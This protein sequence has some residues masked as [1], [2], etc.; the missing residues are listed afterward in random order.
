MDSKIT[1][2]LEEVSIEKVC[3]T[4][5]NTP[6]DDK[7]IS[8]YDNSDQELTNKINFFNLINETFGKIVRNLIKINMITYKELSRFRCLL[9]KIYQI[10]YVVN[11]KR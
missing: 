4:C 1:V 6:G 7:M 8:I 5:L 9:H 10:V 11:V 3:R 2:Q